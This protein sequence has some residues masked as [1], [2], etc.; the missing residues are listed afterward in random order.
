MQS[1]QPHA[2]GRTLIRTQL[3]TDTKRDSY[4]KHDSNR[5]Q[6]FMVRSTIMNEMNPAVLLQITCR[7]KGVTQ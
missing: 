1:F 7:A 2:I 4:R 5:R 6:Q 3:N